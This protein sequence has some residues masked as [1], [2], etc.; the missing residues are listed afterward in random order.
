MP[1][2]ARVEAGKKFE[3]LVIEQYNLEKDNSRPLLKWPGVGRSNWK[4]LLQHNFDPVIFHP[5]LRKSTFTKY[6]AVNSRGQKIEIKK[7]SYS[8]L[9]SWTMYSEPIIKVAPSESDFVPGNIIYDNISEE[10]Y[11]DFIERFMES[12][13]WVN[14]S[15]LVLENIT[16]T[17]IGVYCK[18]GFIPKD[19]LEFKWVLNNGEYGRI[20][21][22]YKRLTIVFRL[23]K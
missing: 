8:K 23:K 13:W 5:I 2:Q 19:E 12:D 6:D 16:N 20:F 14:N 7:Y 3:E 4:K 11:N 22:N 18:D 15:Q 1:V 21:R 9:K 17:S 10:I